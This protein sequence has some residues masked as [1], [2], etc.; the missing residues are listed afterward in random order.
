MITIEL[1]ANTLKASQAVAQMSVKAKDPRK[2]LHGLCVDFDHNK[3]VAT[4]GHT[5]TAAPALITGAW[6][7]A[8]SLI[9]D[10]S[11]A[12]IPAKAELVVIEMDDEGNDI[13][14]TFP[15]S[16]IAPQLLQ[17]IPD[18]KYPDWHRVLEPIRGEQSAYNAVGLN[19]EYLNVVNKVIG[20]RANTCVGLQFY[21]ESSQQAEMIKVLWSNEPEFIH[22]VMS[23]RI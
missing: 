9:L 20:K 10:L 23:C 13:R 2:C 3:L 15:G 16:N 4:N 19:P 1:F 14:L 8:D 5:L 11:Q 6:N 17:R 22:V 18:E 21:G 7:G 12:K